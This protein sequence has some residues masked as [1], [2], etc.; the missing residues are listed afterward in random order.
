M[1]G[2]LVEDDDREVGQQHPGQGEPL[3]LAAGQPGAVLADRGVQAR[4]QAVGPVAEPRLA[5]G[6]T[7]L[8]IG[9]R[10]DRA[11]RRFAAQRR[12]EDVRVLLAQAD[13]GPQARRNPA[14]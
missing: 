9:S 6:V 13:D 8:R 11:S 2:G 5:Q 1:L 14:R 4:G 7:Q 12:V 3:P 10:P